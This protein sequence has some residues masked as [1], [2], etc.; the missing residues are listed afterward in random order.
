VTGAG[1][2]IGAATVR[3]LVA[4]GAAVVGLDIA[5]PIERVGEVDYLLCDVADPEAVEAA[6]DRAVAHL[7]GHGR[8]L[9]V[10][11]NN[12]GIGSLA[13]AAGLAVEEWR[14]VLDVNVSSV[15]YACRRAI[16]IM[17]SLS[18]GTIVNVASISGLRGDFGFGAYNA[19][20]AAVVNYTRTLALDHG[21]DGIRVN[22]VCPG[23]VD[24]P[25]TAGLHSVEGLLDRWTAAIPLGRAGQPDEIAATIAFLASDDASYLT[26]AAVVVDGGITAGTGQPDVLSTI[27]SMLGDT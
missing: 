8:L 14:R 7:D 16:P 6:I 26:G 3:R 20:K 4:E 12:A 21:R 17:Q 10:L 22:A 19:S 1:S 24:T 27:M 11:V 13:P 18:G 5:E 25:L 15:F 2:G 9:D 23:L